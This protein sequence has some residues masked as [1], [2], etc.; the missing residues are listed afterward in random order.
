M[1][2]QSLGLVVYSLV[3]TPVAY[4]GELIMDSDTT[5]KLKNVLVL[6]SDPRGDEGKI[7]ISAVPYASRDSTV[8][9]SKETVPGVLIDHVEKNL[10][11]HYNK[12]LVASYT[13][14]SIVQGL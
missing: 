7:T 4:I 14:L 10:Q 3:R 5:L 13:S 2:E 8:T 1:S 9:F 12:E 6:I 11:S